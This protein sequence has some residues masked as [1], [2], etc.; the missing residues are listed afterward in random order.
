[1]T[2]LF[3]RALRTLISSSSVKVL[4]SSWDILPPLKAF[5]QAYDQEQLQQRMERLD[6]QQQQQ[7]QNISK[8]HSHHPSRS[9]GPDPKNVV[10]GAWACLLPPARRSAL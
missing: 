7:Q 9:I 1:M 8:T 2:R 5:K 6:Q 4:R 10:R 3:K